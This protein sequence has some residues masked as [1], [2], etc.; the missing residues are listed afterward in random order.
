MI[1]WPESRPLGGLGE[2]PIAATTEWVVSH[3]REGRAVVGQTQ[4]SN[5]DALRLAVFG[6]AVELREFVA[7]DFQRAAQLLQCK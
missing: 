4:E 5:R 2:R 3:K 1:S 6:I 7:A